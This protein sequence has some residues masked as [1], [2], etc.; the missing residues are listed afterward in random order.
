MQKT[1]DKKI[2]IMKHIACSKNLIFCSYASSI[3]LVS[4]IVGSGFLITG[5]RSSPIHSMLTLQEFPEADRVCTLNW[6]M[7]SIISAVLCRYKSLQ[8]TIF[9]PGCKNST[10]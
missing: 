9:I 8:E 4:E 10:I 6:Y 2:Q 7:G 1:P 3:N 5:L